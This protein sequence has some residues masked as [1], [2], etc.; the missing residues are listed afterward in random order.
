MESREVEMAIVRLPV[1][2]RRLD[3]PEEVIAFLAGQGIEHER[4]TPARCAAK[5][6]R[7]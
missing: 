2:D 4:W 1:Q 5:Q 6:R 3:A 7:V